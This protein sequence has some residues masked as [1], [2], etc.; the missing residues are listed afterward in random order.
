MFSIL[1]LQQIQQGIDR[2]A[3]QGNQNLGYE[4]NGAEVEAVKSLLRVKQ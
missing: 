4:L 3:A 2:V 1:S